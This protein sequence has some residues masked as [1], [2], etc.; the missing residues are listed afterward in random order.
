MRIVRSVL[1]LVVVSLPFGG[2]VAQSRGLSA[3]AAAFTADKSF[4]AVPPCRILDTRLLSDADRSSVRQVDVQST[5]CVRVLPAYAV[6]Y[7][8]RTSRY[9]ASATSGEV[10]DSHVDRVPV[11]A[12]RKIDVTVPGSSHITLDV[13]GYF[14]PPGIVERPEP[15]AAAGGHPAA[16]ALGLRPAASD[17]EGT[18]R[19]QDVLP[20]TAGTV[21]LR[22]TRS[23]GV[24][25]QSTS[26]S[27]HIL[28]QLPTSDPSSAFWVYN[29]AG[30]GVMQMRGDG[31]L[32]INGA[33]SAGTDYW[34]FNGPKVLGNIVHNVT[35]TN[36]TLD[37][38][39]NTNNKIIFFRAMNDGDVNSPDTTKYEAFTPG[40]TDQT[41]V[42]FDSRILIHKNS[43]YHFRAWSTYGGGTENK[44]TFWVRAGTFGDVVTNTRADMYVSGLVGIGTTTPQQALTVSG[45]AAGVKGHVMQ[46]IGT[47]PNGTYQNQLNITSSP[48][49][50]GL[51]VGQNNGGVTA[52][53]YQCANCAHI[54]NYQASALLLGTSNA[55]R[56]RIDAAGN[57]GIGKTA[58]ATAKLDIAGNVN[59]DGTIN[60]KWQDVAE[61]VNTAE[62]VS[63][64]SVVVVA[65]EGI[66]GVALS[67][68]AYDTHV[69]GVVSAQPGI[70]LGT[71]A[72][73]K[74]KIATTG[75]VKVRVDATR[76][77]IHK[78]DLLVTSDKPGMAMKSEPIDVAGVKI[79]RP[80]TLIGKALEPLAS[81]EGEIL[82]LLSLQ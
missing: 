53:E 78:G 17:A 20:G 47:A 57:V 75:R 6:A 21:D 24:L 49:T 14:V 36:P 60:A 3:G 31:L 2:V 25:M 59:V 82:V 52:A 43:K 39:A 10:L 4:V 44:A 51:I 9:G 8:V 32:R 76:G 77:A 66:D 35:I 30:E 63:S 29:L 27:P 80:G 81:G 13:E 28:A 71:P 55:E 33:I 42:N 45:Y 79:H 61:W 26:A 1:L 74:A 54:I 64:A 62:P 73:G 15:A 46:L 22:G 65:D 56:M 40:Y 11:A 50:W 37:P 38:N 68:T 48:D 70:T 5:R 16:T 34:G 72:D 19:A 67:R 23:S 12:G 69:A 7:A 18:V 41:D 58:A